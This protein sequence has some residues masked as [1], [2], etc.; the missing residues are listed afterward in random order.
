[1]KGGNQQ[2]ERETNEVREE[3]EVF[4]SNKFREV[5]GTKGWTTSSA[6]GR[7]RKRQKRV[8]LIIRKQMIT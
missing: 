5:S 3:T 1:M 6:E 2:K 8:D 7:L 4:N